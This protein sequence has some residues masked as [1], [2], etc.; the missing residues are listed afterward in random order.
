MFSDKIQPDPNGKIVFFY[1]FADVH[2]KLN[3]THMITNSKTP[4]RR[5]GGGNYES[6]QLTIASASI[7]KGFAASG[8]SGNVPLEDESYE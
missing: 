2:N 5:T 6:P 3:I 1:I 4:F 7:E 8:E